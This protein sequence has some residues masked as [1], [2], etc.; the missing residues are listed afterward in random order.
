[1]ILLGLDTHKR[2]LLK[3][4]GERAVGSKSRKGEVPMKPYFALFSR[5]LKKVKRSTDGNY[6]ACCPFHDDRHPSFS[7][8]AET[9]LW[10]C[11][12][13]CGEGNARQFLERLGL[14]EQQIMREL[15][16]CGETVPE[17]VMSMDKW[18]A[19]LMQN[20]N[21][22]RLHVVPDRQKTAVPG[23]AAPS[24]GDSQAAD[25]RQAPSKPASG[26][27]EKLQVELP[28][29]VPPQEYELVRTYTYTDVE[30][31]VLYLKDRYQR[32]SDPSA[33]TFRIRWTGDEKKLV[34]YGLTQLRDDV[35]RIILVEGEKCAEAVTQAL[36]DTDTTTAV[37]GY[38]TPDREFAASRCEG[39][40]RNRKIYIL[41]DNDQPGASKAEAAIQALKP[42]ASAIY[43]YD[44]AGKEEGYDIA[45]YLG[46]GGDL[47]HVIQ[48][49]V[50]VFERPLLEIVLPDI[51]YYHVEPMQFTQNFH[52]PIGVV[53]LLAGTGGTGK[54][55][56]SLYMMLTLAAKE[57]IPCLYVSFEDSKQVIMLRLQSLMK[58]L[59]FADL[60]PTKIGIIDHPAPEDLM[61]L[62]EEA[63]E[64]M[65]YRFIFID[66]IGALFDDE[67]NNAE[68]Q[69]FMRVLNE[70]TT[71]YQGNIMLVHHVRKF[72]V[73]SD[74]REVLYGAVR[75]ASAFVNNARLAWVLR[76]LKI[77]KET[78]PNALQMVGVKSNYGRQFD[79][80][81]RDLF[82]DENSSSL[83][84][85]QVEQ[86]DPYACVANAGNGKDDEPLI[87]MSY[88]G[89]V[90]EG[91]GAGPGFASEDFTETDTIGE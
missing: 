37:L 17:K 21:Q 54:S 13:G 9:G 35:E 23:Q 79:Y 62:I 10:H 6:T 64:R 58:R 74:D 14:S 80:V 25:A 45:D 67:N 5:R 83:K 51:P 29:P 19:S 49:A 75:G 38:N 63:F 2:R 41:A 39:F 52:I 32:K 72:D 1:M 85:V 76:R 28:P 56:V 90:S 24:Q 78:V 87:P 22:N 42:Y 73:Q 48:S 68:V 60:P 88:F 8:H 15:R 66:P 27:A 16:E 65:G 11:F 61:P 81:I 30:G 3:Y 46:E 59:A 4:A 55:Y 43:L 53:G 50:K 18:R 89:R 84:F 33:K 34:F 71:R 7:F 31:N 47:Y 36:S 44:F 12:A 26:K 69:R 70:L 77:K 86:V 40:F 91:G 20:Q 57:Q 82:P